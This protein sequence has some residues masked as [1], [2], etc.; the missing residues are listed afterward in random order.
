MLYELVEFIHVDIRE[1]LRGKV[2]YGNTSYAA[3]GRL[4]LSLSLSLERERE[5]VAVV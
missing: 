3:A 5:R 1:K 4:S 2:S